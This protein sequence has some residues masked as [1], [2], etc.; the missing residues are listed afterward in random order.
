MPDVPKGDVLFPVVEDETL[1]A[2]DE[3]G[4]SL[5]QFLLIFAAGLGLASAARTPATAEFVCHSGASIQVG[6]ELSIMTL[7]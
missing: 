1:G 7:Q 4:T 6:C 2:G 5:W 3:G